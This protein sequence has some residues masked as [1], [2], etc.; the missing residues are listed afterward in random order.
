MRTVLLVGLV[1]VVFLSASRLPAEEDFSAAKKRL[2][3]AFHPGKP[4]QD[5]LDSVFEIGTFDTRD[6]AKLL[7][8]SIKAQDQIVTPLVEE[9]Q[10]LDEE[11]NR[12][13]GP[14]MLDKERMLPEGVG[15]TLRR[16]KR[17]S[18]ELTERLDNEHKVF[19]EIEISIGRY[20][21]ERTVE[22][23]ARTGTDDKHWRARLIVIRALGEIANPT[24]AKHIVSAIGDSDNRVKSAAAQVAGKMKIADALKPLLK[25]LDD[26]VWTVRAAA[27]EALGDIGEK[28]AVG[29]L[30]EQIEEEEGRLREDCAQALAKLTGQQ[31]GQAVG[32]WKKWWEENKHEYGG[33]DGKPLG[34]HPPDRPR[35]AGKG[36]YG[37]P[38]VT[39]KAIFILDVSGSMSKST[40][41]ASR[42]PTQGEISKIERAKRELTRVI[43][44]FTSKGKFNLIIFNDV[45]K[46]WR[47]AMVPAT[48]ANKAAAQDWVKSLGATS[49]TNIYD[50]LEKAFKIAGL[51]V[52]DK[53]YKAEADTIFLLSDGS[54]TKP[55]G[56]ADDWEKIL[57]A[58][59]QWNQLK[60][61]TIHAIG[62]G[63]HNVAFMSRLAAEN[64]GRYV[65]K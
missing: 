36:Y 51:G 39:G 15:D 58:V 30:I 8:K 6:A 49:S 56:E 27:I 26:K 21:N 20:T 52:N 65:S 35:D 64:N 24:T 23:L 13:L 46:A 53:H 47:E 11:I 40:K 9:K 63:G 45:V 32:A 61:V 4:A 37:I 14:K 22:W 33:D 25:L 38:V 1:A 44:N 55:S 62:V 42:D 16:K 28:G 59:R 34:G 3:A 19:E 48:K 29:P 12:I 2:D 5:R 10:E 17:R 43:T 54:P 41:D 7:V 18:A 57:R 50:A 60:K 31:F